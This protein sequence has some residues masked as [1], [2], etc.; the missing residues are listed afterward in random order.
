M[1]S[2]D[3]RDLETLVDD[4]GPN[5]G[6]RLR[7]WVTLIAIFGA[8]A[9]NLLSN[10]F[11]V[12][13][14][15]ISQLSQTLFS[16]VAVI[17]A[18]FAFAIWGLIYLALGA[19]AVYQLAPQRA[20]SPLLRRA[21]YGL[22]IA[23]L[24]QVVWIYAFQSRAFGLSLLP[25]LGIWLSLALLYRATHRADDRREHRWFVHIPISLY[26]A[27]ISVATIVNVAIALFSQ[28]WRAGAQD[29]TIFLMLVATGIASW[30]RIYRGDRVFPSVVA[31]AIA[32]ITLRN[33]SHL[34]L[35]VV[36]VILIAS[37]V[38]QAVVHQW[39]FLAPPVVSDKSSSP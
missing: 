30:L 18:N 27:W 3:P 33:G 4:G 15:T 5:A 14:L 26:F 31:W 2:Q 34:E 32:G 37:L 10:S 28:G 16:G 36:G 22:A 25:M 29:W 21:G 6:D 7:Q 19:H 17:P 39:P 23:N 8:I 13:G 38:F 12:G 24:F 11:P 9:L 20:A 1:A 35:V